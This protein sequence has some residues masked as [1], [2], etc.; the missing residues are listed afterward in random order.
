[1]FKPAVTEINRK[2]NL[3]GR[4]V[5]L[6]T[7]DV[8]STPE[9]AVT[10]A[11]TAI[12]ADQVNAILGFYGPIAMAA[13]PVIMKAKIPMMITM[14]MHG[15]LVRKPGEVGYF[16]SVTPV[17]QPVTAQ[18]KF[19]QDWLKIKSAVMIGPD[20]AFFWETST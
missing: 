18:I 2:G 19:D 1:M 13:K 20:V 17:S 8:K 7:Y 9:E 11:R 14:A 6:L 16:S 10:A 12:S 4:K 5:E 15:D 3:G